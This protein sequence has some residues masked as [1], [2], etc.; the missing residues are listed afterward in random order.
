MTALLIVDIQNDFLPGGA[1]S[2]P[3]GDAVIPVINKLMELN[4]DLVVASKDWHPKDHGSFASVHNKDVGD[5]IL[6]DG[7]DQILWPDHC[8][9]NT[10]GS[11]FAADLNIDPIEHVTHKG[12]DKNIDSYS[13]FFDNE[14]KKS[15]GLDGVLKG[16]GVE[17]LYICGLATDYCVKYS[18]LDACHLGYKTYVIEDACRGVNLSEGDSEK[19]LEEIREAGAHIVR[20]ED[21]VSPC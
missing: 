3:E 17:A 7:L 9:E 18:A 6:L 21:V 2:V 13:A 12:I 16:E 1:L 14:H 15:T 5:H 8:V 4:F 19:A 20:S 11:E 10:T